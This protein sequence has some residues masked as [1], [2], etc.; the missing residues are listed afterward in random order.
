MASGAIRCGRKDFRGGTV[1]S[2]SGKAFGFSGA[3]FGRMKSA[4]K[5]CGVCFIQEARTEQADL[6]FA[7]D[8]FISLG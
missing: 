2:P 7:S 8:N 4:T 3:I 6:I 5:T 1:Q